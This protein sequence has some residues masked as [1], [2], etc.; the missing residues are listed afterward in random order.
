MKFTGTGT[1]GALLVLF[2]LSGT[3]QGMQFDKTTEEGLKK[4][5]T[6]T[7]KTWSTAKDPL[8]HFN[9]LVK[10]TEDLNALL[11]EYAKT[12]PGKKAKEPKEL[13]TLAGDFLTTDPTI[14]QAFPALGENTDSFMA[15]HE[16]ELQEAKADFDKI[17]LSCT[18]FI[19]SPARTA[20][21]PK[22]FAL[23][24]KRASITPDE[25]KASFWEEM[26]KATLKEPSSYVPEKI[27]QQA[28]NKI[29]PKT[30]DPKENPFDQ[31]IKLLQ[32][33]DTDYPKGTLLPGAIPLYCNAII[34]YLPQITDLG[35]EEQRGYR[36]IGN[37]MNN[38]KKDTAL[39]AI[40]ALDPVKQVVAAM[41]K[42]AI[43]W[44]EAGK[45]PSTTFAGT[46]K[47]QLDGILK[48]PF[49]API[50]A[51]VEKQAAKELKEL[52]KKLGDALKSL[53]NSFAQLAGKL[54]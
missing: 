18:L 14:K 29:F 4:L 37:I 46:S 50:Y 2:C 40:A 31:I 41:E 30:I 44:A 21:D 9:V 47:E 5:V 42:Q 49:L 35:P 54:K 8:E 26:L 32:T 7:T 15:A 36:Y 23:L 10:M 33:L 17:R 53:S 34:A 43:T 27:L 28:A 16:K 24:E 22:A 12:L 39:P 20:E 51:I 3:L 25:N 1:L 52:E 13:I 19:D 6:D 11:T 48:D 45:F 38:L